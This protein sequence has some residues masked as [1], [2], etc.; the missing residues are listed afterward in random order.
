MAM[1]FKNLKFNQAVPDSTFVY[2]PP[3]NSQVIDLT[4]MMLAPPPPPA[5]G[6]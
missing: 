3:A 4:P 6:K 1:E 5:G 2:Q